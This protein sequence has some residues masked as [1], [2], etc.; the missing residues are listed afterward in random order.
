MGKIGIIRSEKLFIYILTKNG[1]YDYCDAEDV[2]CLASTNIRKILDYLSLDKMPYEEMME[3]EILI[4]P[5]GSEDYETISVDKEIDKNLIRYAP[6]L[7]LK[8]KDVLQELVITTS[9]WRKNLIEE[10]EEQR[11]KQ[12]EDKVRKQEIRERALYEKLKAKYEK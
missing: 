7:L 3:Y 2:I 1:C 6:T 12:E 8:N 5:D 9:V 10:L 11:R 4:K